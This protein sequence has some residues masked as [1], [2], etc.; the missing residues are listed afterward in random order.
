MQL[1]CFGCGELGHFAT[2]CPLKK[3][4]EEASDSKAAPT[5]DDKEGEDDDCAMSAHAPLEKKWGDMEL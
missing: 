1:I 2:Q 3:G 5:K 4:K